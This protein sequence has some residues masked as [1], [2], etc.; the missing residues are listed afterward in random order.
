[1][2]QCWRQYLKNPKIPL[3][4]VYSLTSYLVS[5][6]WV[7]LPRACLKRIL[8]LGGKHWFQW[9]LPIGVAIYVSN[10]G[11]SQISSHMFYWCLRITYVVVELLHLFLQGKKPGQWIRIHIRNP[12]PDPGEQKWPTKDEKRR[13]FMFE[14]LDVLFWELKASSVTWTSFMEA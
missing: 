10:R 1:M 3:W 13:N 2:K 12:D 4:S 5:Q 11:E 9:R 6:A 14:V 8:F 7:S